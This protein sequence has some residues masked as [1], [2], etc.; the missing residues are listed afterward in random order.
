MV[1][2]EIDFGYFLAECGKMGAGESELKKAAS[3]R[4]TDNGED[5]KKPCNWDAKESKWVPVDKL[6]VTLNDGADF[7][8][9][10]MGRDRTLFELLD[11]DGKVIWKD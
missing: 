1:I 7:G 10:R 11:K 5:G 2:R 6:A 9:V 8:R 3:I 4:F